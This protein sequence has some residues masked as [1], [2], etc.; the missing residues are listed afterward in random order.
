ME[1]KETLWKRLHTRLN[2]NRIFRSFV[3][4]KNVSLFLYEDHELSIIEAGQKYYERSGNA[5]CFRLFVCYRCRIVIDE[6]AESHF[7]CGL[8]PSYDR[9]VN[10]HAP[11]TPDIDL[12]LCLSRNYLVYQ[13]CIESCKTVELN[14]GLNGFLLICR[15]PR[16]LE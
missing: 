9:L 16:F 6:R 14:E 2:W 15:F 3:R 8:N 4:A 7:Y 5:R 1:K 13:S 12:N 11:C 10:V